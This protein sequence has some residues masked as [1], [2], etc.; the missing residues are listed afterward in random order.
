MAKS[1]WLEELTSTPEE[2]LEFQQ[3]KSILHITQRIWDLMEETGVSRA[4]LAS[5]LGKSRSFV[6]QVLSGRTN[7]TVRTLSSIL[8]AL[9]RDFRLEISPLGKPGVGATNPGGNISTKF[10]D[11]AQKTYRSYSAPNQPVIRFAGLPGG[12]LPSHSTGSKKVREAG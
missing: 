9:G 4:E 10:T 7:M 12:I 2:L 5:R 6:S 11:A 3:E 8:T 1:A